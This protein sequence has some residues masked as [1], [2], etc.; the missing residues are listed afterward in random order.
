METLFNS[1]EEDWYFWSEIQES[2]DSINDS[3][4]ITGTLGLWDGNHEIFPVEVDS[5]NEALEK[6]ISSDIDNIVLKHNNDK[7]ELDCYHHDGINHFILETI[8]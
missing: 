4:K 5:I 7:Y 1:F 8:K 3:I 2:L 6:C